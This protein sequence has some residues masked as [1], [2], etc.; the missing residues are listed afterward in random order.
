MPT[1]AQRDTAHAIYMNEVRKLAEIRYLA[2]KEQGI[3][4]AYDPQGRILIDVKPTKDEIQ[5]I[6]LKIN[7]KNG[8]NVQNLSLA[9]RVSPTPVIT[10]S[11]DVGDD[12]PLLQLIQSALL[13]TNNT[14]QPKPDN[15]P[16]LVESYLQS[17]GSIIPLQEEFHYH[18]AL[19]ARVYADGVDDIK[20]KAQIEEA[21]VAAVLRVNQKVQEVFKAAIR[22]AH[23]ESS[24]VFNVKDVN[25]ILAKAREELMK[26]GHRFLGEEMKARG[27]QESQLTGNKK[28]FKHKAETIPAT[29]NALIFVDKLK[30]QPGKIYYFEGAG[31][32]TSHVRRQGELAG[33]VQISDCDI[34][35]QGEI[36]VKKH[37]RFQE[38]NPSLDV[39]KGLNKEQRIDDVANKL[40]Q[41]SDKYEFKEISASGPGQ[42]SAFVYN[43]H[44]ALSSD[45][46]QKQ[47]AEAIIQGAH[48]FNKVQLGETLP[49]PICLVQNISVN[50]F[51]PKLSYDSKDPLV[52]EAKL[53][54]DMAM[55]HTLYE[56]STPEEKSHMDNVFRLYKEFLGQ[57]PPGDYFSKDPSFQMVETYIHVLKA[58]W[59]KNTPP[60]VEA[61]DAIQ[62]L[63]DDSK[64]ELNQEEI[65]DILEE[66]RY[67]SLQG[68]LKKLMAA[69][70]DGLSKYSKLIPSL[71]VYLE[72]VSIS[73]C[74]SANERAQAI[75]GRVAV[76]DKYVQ[77]TLD[78]SLS[79]DIKTALDQFSY[80]TKPKEIEKA[81]AELNSALDKAYNRDW[82]YSAMARMSFRDQGGPA[83]LAPTVSFSISKVFKW[84]R[85][86]VDTN[87][88][89]NSGITNL[90]D[91]NSK[92]MQAHNGMGEAMAKARE[93]VFHPR[94][95]DK[96]DMEARKKID[97]SNSLT[98]INPAAPK[99]V[100]S[101]EAV[102][103]L[104]IKD[105]KITQVEAP[106]FKPDYHLTPASFPKGAVLIHE[107]QSNITRS[108]NNR[109]TLSQIE[110]SDDKENDEKNIAVERSPHQ[111][112]VTSSFRNR[113][114]GTLTTIKE[115]T[116]EDIAAENDDDSQSSVHRL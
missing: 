44:T 83:K 106:N 62:G 27:I 95:A 96:K 60:V 110:K 45:N 105:G 93:E 56:G 69:D 53:M 103:A 15:T 43:L 98:G 99:L 87:W 97:I 52:K 112:E 49:G 55:M 72:T 115:E 111:L 22:E 36:K 70:L 79:R 5:A 8:T 89:E 57:N 3:P 10:V 32:N 77:G 94:E 13:K 19:A 51:G 108:T 26:E 47:G 63:Y 28:E 101:A 82:L 2:A 85:S 39:K 37:P 20:V 66:K 59:Q 38:R 114:K 86:Q 30:G 9:M 42:T 11:Y 81:A 88:G 91:K 54:A 35:Q 50:G 109:P 6:L 78:D 14:P 113:L 65:N 64:S 18:L 92:I 73:G 23:D 68:G 100:T 31:T 104:E 33:S 107:S 12:E 116:P 46:Q 75:N 1:L 61:A 4:L 21:Q 67:Q 41:I 16:Q 84:L 29:E 48:Q 40:N 17:R 74:K 25:E 7:I 24:T 76:L 102:A 34:N 90:I 71:S 80:A 58:E